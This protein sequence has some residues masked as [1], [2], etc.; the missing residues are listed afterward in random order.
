VIR[1]PK[2]GPRCRDRAD[3]YGHPTRCTL[4]V[5]EHRTTADVFGTI[6]IVEHIG[7]Q[8]ERWNT[9][10]PSS[11]ADLAAADEPDQTDRDRALDRVIATVRAEASRAEGVLIPTTA[12]VFLYRDGVDVEVVRPG[13]QLGPKYGTRWSVAT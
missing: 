1:T 5:D 6:L 13:G 2:R 3:I 7:P 8:G 12:T 9:T 11:D 10:Y 4:T